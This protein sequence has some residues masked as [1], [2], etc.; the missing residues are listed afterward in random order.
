MVNLT[1]QPPYFR[2]GTMVQIGWAPEPEWTSGKEK[3]LLFVPEFEARTVQPV[4]NSLYVSC[5][6]GFQIFV[7]HGSLFKD[8]FEKKKEIQ[9]IC[10]E[11]FRGIFW[12]NICPERLRIKHKYSRKRVAG[13][14]NRMQT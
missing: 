2:E 8:N 9:V 13:A 11:A 5:Y 7:I 6:P 3:I 12:K 10:K 14:V 1:F 4:D